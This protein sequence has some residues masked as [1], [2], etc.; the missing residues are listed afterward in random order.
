VKG[1][2]LGTDGGVAG[3][4]A[5]TA[6]A[7]SVR[8]VLTPRRRAQEEFAD[9]V[10]VTGPEFGRVAWFLAGDR[11]RAEDLLQDA[12]L[13]TWAHWS[14]V[15]EG[16]PVAYTRSVLANARIDAWRLGRREVLAAE[17]PEPA[18]GG[19]ADS[20]AG[21]AVVD[22]RGMLVRALRSLPDKQRRIVVLRHLVG[23]PEAQVAVDLG[24]SVGTVKA[25]A[26]RGLARLR[27]LLGEDLEDE[28]TGTR[29]TDYEG[30]TR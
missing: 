14:R 16:D 18:D 9:F 7:D 29:R 24:V 2:P 3:D 23:L 19:A 22:D 27:D 5:D 25:A 6:A 28:H 10:R 4:P 30:R 8:V 15:R 21:A 1:V 12:Y 26:S 13:R 20:A 17:V 11:T